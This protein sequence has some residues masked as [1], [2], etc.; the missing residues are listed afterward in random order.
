MS[1]LQKYEKVE[2]IEKKW[3]GFMLSVNSPLEF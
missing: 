1:L 3:D 2:E